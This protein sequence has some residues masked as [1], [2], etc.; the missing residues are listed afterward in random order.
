MLINY[1]TITKYYQKILIKT[2]CFWWNISWRFVLLIKYWLKQRLSILVE[3]IN[4]PHS[5]VSRPYLLSQNPKCGYYKYKLFFNQIIHPLCFVSLAERVNTLFC[6]DGV[7]HAN[8][9]IQPNHFVT[10]V[11]WENSCKRSYSNKATKSLDK[12]CTKTINET[13]SQTRYSNTP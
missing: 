9:P 1:E 3:I 2:M 13:N 12:K 4:G 7:Q 6:H 10:L 8:S 11:F 5:Y